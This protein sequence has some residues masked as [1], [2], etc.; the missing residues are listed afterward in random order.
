MNFNNDNDNNSSSCSFFSDVDSDASIENHLPH[1]HMELIHK[2]HLIIVMYNLLN[3]QMTS[4]AQVI[5][6]WAVKEEAS[7]GFAENMGAA[8]AVDSFSL[9]A[10]SLM[11]LL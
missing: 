3:V 1:E 7:H 9:K 4:I 11:V 10:R 5:N 8:M 6:G 2:L